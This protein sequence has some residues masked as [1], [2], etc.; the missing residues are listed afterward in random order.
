MQTY[1]PSK[2]HIPKAP[3]L[4][5]L[6]EQPKFGVYNLRVN[7]SN[8]TIRKREP[9]GNEAEAIQTDKAVPQ[10]RETKGDPVLS[11][12]D[13]A[14]IKENIDFEPYRDRIEQ[15]K[16]DHIYAAMRAEEA[17]HHM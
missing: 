6:L 15:F 10:E 17:E 5:L 12:N 2:I 9:E 11:V 7:E 1:G 4:G 3:A 14:T 8:A 13:G 16:R